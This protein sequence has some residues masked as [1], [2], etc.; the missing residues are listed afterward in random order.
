MVGFG[1]EFII[2]RVMFFGV[3][4]LAFGMVIFTVIKAFNQSNKNNHSPRLTVEALVVAKRTHVSRHGSRND[5][6]HTSAYTRYYATFQVASG[7]RMELQMD[8]NAYGMLV[9][10]DFGLL[11]FQGTRYLDF[12]RGRNPMQGMG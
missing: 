2:F 6:F 8:G 11:T 10:G 4:A 3:F 9:E 12:A 5:D 1:F 7:D